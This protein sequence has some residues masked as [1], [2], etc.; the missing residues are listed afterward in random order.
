MIN[1][2]DQNFN[3]EVAKINKPILLDFWAQWCTPCLMFAPILDELSKEFEGKVVFAKI[4]VDES[5]NMANQFKVESIPSVFLINKEQIL[6]GFK[7][8]RQKE[9]VKNWIEEK[10]KE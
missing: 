1:L 6:G 10:T 2:T 9:E 7:G 3:E 4:N 8:A 5:P